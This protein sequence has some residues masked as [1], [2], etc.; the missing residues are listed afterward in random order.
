MLQLFEVRE[1]VGF[2]RCRAVR[3]SGGSAP[4]I[5]VRGLP[6]VRRA[7]PRERRV[8]DAP[9]PGPVVRS[10]AACACV[11]QSEA[12]VLVLPEPV[13][14]PR[15]EAAGPRSRS[16]R[17]TSVGSGSP[18]PK[19]PIAG[20]A[21]ARWR[22]GKRGSREWRRPRGPVCQRRCP[23][24]TEAWARPKSLAASRAISIA[25][26]TRAKARAG[27]S[28]IKRLASS[29]STLHRPVTSGHLSRYRRGSFQPFDAPRVLRVGH[30]P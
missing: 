9:Q 27:S 8:H 30:G 11:R 6:L 17:R 21:S 20:P 15:A 3:A 23:L 28:S 14:G 2:F 25:S 10:T 29:G 26:S 1:G 13:H 22:R 16:T 18:G 5:S 7:G 12:Q 24:V 4:R 19:C